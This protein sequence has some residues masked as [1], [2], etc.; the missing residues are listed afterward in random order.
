M[1]QKPSIDNTPSN[2]SICVIQYKFDNC[3]THSILHELLSLIHTCNLIDR[4]ENAEN[5]EIV[6]SD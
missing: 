4:L 2:F 3:A 1:G 5:I 6:M